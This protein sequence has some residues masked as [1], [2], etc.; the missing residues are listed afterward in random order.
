MEKAKASI[1]KY[2]DWRSESYITDRTAEHE[3]KWESIFK[4][5]LTDA[6]GKHALDIGTGRGHFAFYLARLGFDVKGIDLSEKMVYHAQRSAVEQNLDI[7]FSTGDAERLD[8]VDNSFDV[9]VSRNLLWTLPYP[10]KAI[11]E[12][13]RVMKPG[14]T[15]V[16]SDGF[17]MNYTWKR[18]HHLAFNLLRNIFCPDNIISLRFFLNYASIQRLLPFYEGICHEKASALLQNACFKDIKLYDISS[19]GINPYTQGKRL[20]KNRE[21]SFFIAYAER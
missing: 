2:W 20:K 14:G 5:L 9:V 16:L 3:K 7:E 1:K 8:F 13:R 11:E 17:W 4:E 21:P 15:L 6:P 19:F 12:W 18:V 10:E